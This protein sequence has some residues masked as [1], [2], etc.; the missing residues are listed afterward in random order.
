MVKFTRWPWQGR[1]SGDAHPRVGVRT[2]EI[3]RHGSVLTECECHLFLVL[4]WAPRRGTQPKAGDFGKN[5][6]ICTQS[7]GR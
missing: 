7:E 6:F 5:A 4:C 2:S 3:I 1:Y